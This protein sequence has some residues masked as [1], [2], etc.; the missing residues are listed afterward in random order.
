MI[1]TSDTLDSLRVSFDK[2]YMTA[3]EAAESQWQSIATK[4]NAIDSGKKIYGWLA[5]QV[6]LEE[7]FKNEPRKAQQLREHE[8]E[9]VVRKFQRAIEV[10][11]EKIEDD[12][13][14]VYTGQMLPQLGAA[15]KKHPDTLARDV[16]QDTTTTYWDGEAL[17]SDSH[18]TFEPGGGTYDNN[19]ALALTADNFDTVWSAMAGY[20]GEDGLPLGIM[21]NVLRVP[22]QLRR[23][24]LEVVQAAT[25][26]K[27]D[28]TDA[29]ALDN[30]LV[31]WAQVIVDP[32]LANEP[33]TWYLY[34]NTRGVSPLVFA[35]R[36]APELVAR[37]NPDDPAVFE[38]DV[39]T[40]GVR[41]R[42]EMAPT[43]PFL[44]SKS[45]A[46]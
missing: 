34:D 45:V 29:V 5:Q 39:Y 7:W 13:L 46:P 37:F 14:S 2:K 10:E 31:G 32:F 21:P 42:C 27:S 9:V 20:V 36:T 30:V 40:W 8:Q 38:L 41:Y 17:F 19:F 4:D 11:R 16:L 23:T 6:T 25:V 35:E 26:F 28:G 18:P 22:P 12:N 3:Y 44:I 33:G 15:A 1:I 24:A 43:L